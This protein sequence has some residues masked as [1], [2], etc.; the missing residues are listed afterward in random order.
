[1]ETTLWAVKECGGAQF[2]DARLSQRLVSITAALTERPESSLPQALGSWAAVKGAYRFMDHPQVNSQ[3]ILEP[4][5]DMTI[6]R[7]QGEK[8]VLAVQDTTVISLSTHRK[9]E[10]LGPIGPKYSLGMLLHSSLGVS[11]TGTPLG[12]LH[13]HYWARTEEAP[14]GKESERWIRSF[15][16]SVKGIPEGTQLVMIGDRESDIFD[17]FAAA[18][19]G[20]RD[21]LVRG[22]HNRKLFGE[23]PDLAAA[24]DQAPLLGT[25]T[26][27]IPRKPEQPEREATLAI[28]ATA[29][30]IKPP[31]GR[32]KEYP[33]GIALTAV[34]VYEQTPPEGEEP[35]GWV[36]LS[37]LPAKTLEQAA[38]LVRWYTYR[39]RIE[40]FHF[41]LKSGCHIEQLQLQT[42]ERLENAIAV[43][44]IVAWRLL[45]LTYQ[46]RETPD[47]P[48]TVAFSDSEWKALYV[49]T[50]KSVHVPQTP[51]TLATAV[52]WLAR[53]GGFLARKSDGNPGVKV[54]WR[55]LRRLEDLVTMWNLLAKPR[56]G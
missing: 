42:A 47:A 41:V 28:N 10:G 39:W 8:I 5:R 16:E 18:V 38:T 55:G 44:S 52:L 51:P 22:T 48:C 26:A 46:A 27:T 53:L 21:V 15:E 7:I 54:L 29:V 17:L 20:V 9:T 1:M 4:H 14:E 36:L 6:E 2:G 50:H 23:H 43:Y 33:S 11:T 3:A 19:P 24:L 12:L 30:T 13:Q 40:R 34:C 56:Y 25:V 37:T 45:W 35:I 49:G 31:A 32:R